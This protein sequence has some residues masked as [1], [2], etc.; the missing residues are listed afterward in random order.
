MVDFGRRSILRISSVGHYDI[1][2]GTWVKQPCLICCTGMFRF[3]NF[4]L[5]IESY[6]GF[7]GASW[8]YQGY[9]T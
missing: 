9:M 2:T 1:I 5:M 4:A 3:L 8:P 7:N 6:P